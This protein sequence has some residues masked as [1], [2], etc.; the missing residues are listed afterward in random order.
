M[1]KGM[2]PYLCILHVCL[3]RIV[4]RFVIYVNEYKCMRML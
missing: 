1:D 2:G 4:A 3:D